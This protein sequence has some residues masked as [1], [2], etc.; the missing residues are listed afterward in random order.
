LFIEFTQKGDGSVIKNL[1]KMPNILLYA[2][3]EEETSRRFREALKDV[4]AGEDVRVSSDIGNLTEWLSEAPCIGTIL[5]ILVDSR[6]D[7]AELFS[8]K[9]LLFDVR[10]ILVLPDKNSDTVA[11]GH[12]LRPRFISYR[13]GNFLDVAAVLARMIKAP[14]SHVPT[15]SQR[16]PLR[17]EP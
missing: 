11:I 13:D 17:N 14:V 4:L 9:K 5:L 3:S 2:K 12:L 16:R 6:E 7:L 8:I 10:T 15:E 1:K